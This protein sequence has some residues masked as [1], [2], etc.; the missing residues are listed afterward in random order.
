MKKLIIV[1][2]ILFSLMFS[3]T[4]FA[5]W[6]NIIRNHGGTTFYLDVLRIAKNDRYVYFWEL[7]DYLKPTENGVLSHQVFAQGDC[8]LIKKKTVSFS[9]Y[10]KPMGAG[11][12]V[13]YEPKNS[14]WVKPS[15]GSAMETMVKSACELAR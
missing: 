7:I 14:I 5:R 13:P 12:G 9:S 6:T 8:K 15:P 11:K 3:S 4:S 1:S 2:A 10:K